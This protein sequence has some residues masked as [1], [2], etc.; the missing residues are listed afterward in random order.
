VGVPH[1]VE[2]VVVGVHPAQGHH[3]ASQ[4][5]RGRAR[6][7]HGGKRLVERIERA[8]EDP[9][10]LPG[11]DREGPLPESRDAREGRFVRSQITIE[12]QE[13]ASDGGSRMR[14]RIELPRNLRPR[15]ALEGVAGEELGKRL[16][17]MDVIET[18]RLVRELAIVERYGFR[19]YPSDLKPKGGKT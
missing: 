10:L 6:H 8:A 4:E 18:E 14:A 17:S 5:R 11:Y 16:V 12:V 9:D 13:G 3:R 2:V 7:A 15:F 1:I 19:H